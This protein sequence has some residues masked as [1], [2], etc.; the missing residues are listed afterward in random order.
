MERSCL[1]KYRFLISKQ[2]TIQT[3]I[4]NILYLIWGFGF[5]CLALGL[6]TQ[7]ESA[8]GIT[9][10][11]LA[12][13]FPTYKVASYPWIHCKIRA[14]SWQLGVMLLKDFMFHSLL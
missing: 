9:T 6:A 5:V 3:S 8:F 13:L 7:N 12:A 11:M 14:E 2:K 4:G 10:E 1:S